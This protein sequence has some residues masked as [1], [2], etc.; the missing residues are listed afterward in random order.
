MRVLRVLKL[1]KMNDSLRIIVDGLHE[2]G[3][4]LKMV[5]IIGSTIT[6]V[7]GGLLYVAEGEQPYSEDNADTVFDS[8]PSTFWFVI[9]SITTVGNS[10]K[11]IESASG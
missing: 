3:D 6:I 4:Y 2:S 5:A 10:Q 7:F 9:A 11:R 1:G 8:V